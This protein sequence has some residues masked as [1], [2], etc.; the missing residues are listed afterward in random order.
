MVGKSFFCSNGFL[1][2]TV[3]AVGTVASLVGNCSIFPFVDGDMGAV[4]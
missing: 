4:L 3:K 1:R 2:P